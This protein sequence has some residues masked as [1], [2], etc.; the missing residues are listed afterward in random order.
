MEDISREAERRAFL[1][2]MRTGRRL[3]E[4]GVAPV[5]RKF[6]PWH[7]PANGQFT[8]GGGGASGSWDRSGPARARPSRD[9]SAA[10]RPPRPNSARRQPPAPSD[11]ARLEQL[12]RAAAAAQTHRRSAQPHR[13]VERNRY[14]YE[15]DRDNRTREASGHL[16]LGPVA[17]RSR[18]AQARAGGA[19]RRPGDD[20]GHYIASRFNGPGDAFNHFAQ[21][22]R[23]N[24]G[25]YRA[26][27]D[28]WAR[29]LRQG[30]SV[31]VRIQP[32]YAGH[33]QRPAWLRVRSTIDGNTRDQIF[34]N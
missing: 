16:S 9:K 6:N 27:E 31:F 12:R 1:V 25:S 29:A 21:S 5:E 24:R 20:G 17:P 3:V 28:T 34:P 11:V 22:A 18:L 10:T 2:W 7:D 30:K 8:F 13:I 4:P 14:R 32:H 33:S 15:I 23:F 26:L 19:D